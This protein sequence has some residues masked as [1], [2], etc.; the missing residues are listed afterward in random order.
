LLLETPII[1]GNTKLCRLRSNQKPSRSFDDVAPGFTR[2]NNIASREDAMSMRACIDA[3]LCRVR[4]SARPFDG[5][6]FS[7]R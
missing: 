3:H 4:R 6:H 7:E 1:G 2:G 5:P